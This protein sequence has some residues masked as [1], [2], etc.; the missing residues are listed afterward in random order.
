M[1][2]CIIWDTTLCSQVKGSRRVG[3]TYDLQLQGL[4]KPDSVLS[5]RYKI[6]LFY[7]DPSFFVRSS[8]R[9]VD[10]VNWTQE[11]NSMKWTCKQQRRKLCWKTEFYLVMT[12]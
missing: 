6:I 9:D 4:T 2:I 8:F 5:D 3:G 1:K 12:D 7:I 10:M 11:V